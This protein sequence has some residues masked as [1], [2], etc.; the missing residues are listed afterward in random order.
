MVD[1]AADRGEDTYLLIFVLAAD[2]LR[3][4]GVSVSAGSEFD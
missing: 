1:A 3:H 2:H 4:L